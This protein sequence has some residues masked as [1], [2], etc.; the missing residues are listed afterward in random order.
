MRQIAT[1]IVALACLWVAPAAAERAHVGYPNSIIVIGHS[2]ATGRNSDPAR[3][4]ADATENSWATGTNPAVNSVYLRILA[5]NPAI[6]GHNVNIARD[7]ATMRGIYGQAAEAATLKRKPE[8]VLIQTIDNDISCRADQD[9][10]ARLAEF[11]N[12][13]TKALRIL[14]R[15]LP[16]ARIFIPSQFASVQNY[17]ETIQPIPEAREQATLNEPCDLFDASGNLRPAGIALLQT[18]VNSYH[19]TEE[20]VCAQFIHCRYDGGAFAR[21]KIV[22]ADLSSDYGHLSIAGHAKL[23][24]VAWSAMFDFADTSAPV[25]S[26][27]RI[28]R[29]VTL[30]A[31]DDAGVAGIEY[32]LTAPKKKAAKWFTRYVKPVLVKKKWTL[33]WRAVD[34]NGNSEATHVLRG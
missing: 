27:T 19:A 6:R 33:T 5:V 29:T 16:N 3:P 14:S 1:A 12:Y 30:S 13:L 4:D 17:A 28:G 20:A 22:L 23:A 18:I 2:G 7:G 15:G 25:S 21:A 26:A 24:A 9:Q 10:T 34:V 32:K 31:T 8:L 11:R